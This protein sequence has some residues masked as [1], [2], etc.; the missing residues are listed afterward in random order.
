[1]DRKH[2]WKRR[3][4]SLR[5]ISPFPTVFSKDLYW[6]HVKTSACLGNGEDHSCKNVG[7]RIMQIQHTFFPVRTITTEA[8]S[9]IGN[10]QGFTL[11]STRYHKILSFNIPKE[12]LMKTIQEQQKVL[13]TSISYL[14]KKC[15]LCH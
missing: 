15:F 5:A 7:I 6:R 1:M 14:S 12:W 4:C 11:I 10:V 13:V 8:K 3:N 2:C 9:R